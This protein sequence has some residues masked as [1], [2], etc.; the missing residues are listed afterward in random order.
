[1]KCIPSVAAWLVAVVGCTPTPVGVPSTGGSGPPSAGS[2]G[3][4]GGTGGVEA[5]PPPIPGFVFPPPS[6]GGS[7]DVK[8]NC[9]EMAFNL[10]RLPAQILVV[11]DR[12]T[13][14][15]TPVPPAVGNRWTN[16][17]E[18][19]NETLTATN[20]TVL[21]GLKTFPDPSAC[22]VA[23]GVNVPIAAMNAVPVASFIQTIGPNGNTPTAAAV[24][25]AADYLRGLPT[26]TARYIVLATDGEPN[27]RAGGNATTEDR[28]GAVL[29]VAAAAAEGFHT[30]VVG[31]ATTLTPADA[32]LSLMAVAG[33]E[34]RAVDPKYY[35]VSSRADLVAALGLITGKVASCVFPLNQLPPST[36]DV[37]VRI[38]GVVVQRDPNHAMGWDLTANGTAVEVYGGTC[39]MLK[40]GTTD[41]V[42]IVYGCFI[43]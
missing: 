34:P 9:G 39:D 30:F 26:T 15:N 28:D 40:A 3:P 27:C 16:V 42:E 23:A 1:M 8:N 21:W 18:A 11:L 2:G 20:S 29:A 33:L 5:G 25:R 6:D 14:M 17:T 22:S 4:T 13:S 31:I 36:G 32:T 7:A 41:K 12:S 38:N 43:P 24:A 10:E 37:T 35:P 19:L